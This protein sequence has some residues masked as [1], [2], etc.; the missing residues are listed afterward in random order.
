[1][2]PI[3]LPR[4]GISFCSSGTAGAGR[5]P[6]PSLLKYNF[7]EPSEPGQ[8]A[9]DAGHL[10]AAGSSGY[11]LPTVRE[12][13]QASNPSGYLQPPQGRRVGNGQVAGPVPAML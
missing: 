5:Q 9:F 1:M 7:H 2:A 3:P 8:A 13:Q 6:P 11:W 12:L 10:D 4:Q